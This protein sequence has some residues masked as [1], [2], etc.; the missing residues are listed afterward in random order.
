VSAEEVEKSNASVAAAPSIRKLA[1]DLG[2]DLTRIR[3]SAPGGRITTEDVR[4]YIQRFATARVAT[5]ISRW[6]KP[7]AESVDFSKRGSVTK[8]PLSP[9]RQVI[10]RRMTKTGTRFR[11]SRSSTT[12]TSPACSRCAK[13]MSALREKIARPD[14]DVVRSESGGGHAEETMPF[15]NSSLDEVANEICFQ[16][17]VHIGIAVDTES[18]LIV[19]HSRRGQKKICAD[20]QRT[21]RTRQKRSDRKVSGEELK[22]VRSRFPIR[23]ESAGAHFSPIVNKPEVAILGLGKGALKAV[24]RDGKIEAERCADWFVIRPR[25]IDGGNAARF[26]VDLIRRLRL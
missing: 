6:R 13:N 20:F 18:G 15:F 11:T 17:Y 2:I 23:A 1:R 10:G 9:C 19:P 21:R 12:P 14:G 3:G 26:T 5:E 24:V 7:P 25:V 22:G 16:E 8:K 4:N